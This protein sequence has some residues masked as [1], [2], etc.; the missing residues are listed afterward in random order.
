M[1]V[2]N[3]TPDLINENFVKVLESYFGF[4][5]PKAYRKFLLETNGGNPV[6]G[7]FI[8]KGNNELGGIRYF[9][10]ISPEYS[11]GLLERW[12]MY[13]GRI[14]ANT[15]AIG[16]NSGGNLILLSVKGSDHGKIYYWDHEMEADEGQTPDYR[17]LTLIAD[18]FE[19]FINGLKSDEEIDHAT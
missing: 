15:I 14:P 17:N 6:K 9:L 19:E 12:A 5:F 1:I 2:E 13:C 16:S 8:M 10:G 18:S 11:K 3:P 7:Y 4:K